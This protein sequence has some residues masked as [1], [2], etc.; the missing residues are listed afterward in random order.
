MQ[1]R[2]P[3][4]IPPGGKKLSR[5]GAQM[6]SKP[7]FPLQPNGPL[8]LFRHQWTSPVSWEA[9]P[10]RQLSYS[11][12]LIGSASS[13]PPPNDTV[14][15]NGS[16]A[17][18]SPIQHERAA[19][20][21]ET[22]VAGPAT[23]RKAINRQVAQGNTALAPVPGNLTAGLSLFHVFPFCCL[24]CK[25]CSNVEKDRAAKKGGQPELSIFFSGSSRKRMFSCKF[26]GIKQGSFW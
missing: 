14:E 5:R 16:L 21:P 9:A 6:A 25:T 2:L 26:S 22:L 20:P 17:L 13:S 12:W 10:L 3:P 18:I 15:I 8:P 23:L 4:T 19:V 1:V 24:S 11:T 7:T